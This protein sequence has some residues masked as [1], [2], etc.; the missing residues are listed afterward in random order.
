MPLGGSIDIVK[1]DSGVADLI[2][3]Y[4][5]KLNSLS[6]KTLKST[7]SFIIIL[8]VGSNFFATLIIKIKVAFWNVLKRSIAL[9]ILGN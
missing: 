8:L 1:H 5:Q 4:P 7:Y 9:S 6:G 2:I 3:N